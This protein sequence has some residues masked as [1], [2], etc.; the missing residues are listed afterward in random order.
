MSGRMVTAAWGSGQ[1]VMLP[2]E[3]CRAAR[4]WF[5]LVA[6]WPGAGKSTLAAALAAGL[7]VPLPAKDD[8]KEALLDGLGRPQTVTA[9]L[10][11]VFG[12]T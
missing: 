7:G 6:G 12:A 10:A 8:I 2:D 3:V 5:V 1:A 4:G 11:Q 9:T